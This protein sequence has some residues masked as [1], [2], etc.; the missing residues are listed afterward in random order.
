MAGRTRRTHAPAFKAK[1]AL[2]AIK[3]EKTLAGLAQHYD[4]HPNQITAWK[5]QLVEGAQDISVSAARPGDRAAEP[6]LGE[7]GQGSD[8]AAVGIARWRD[9]YHV[10]P[11]GTRL[12]LPRGRGELV[13]PAGFGLAAFDHNGVDFCIDA[14]EEALAKYGRPEIF[15]TDQGAQFTSAF[16][17]VCVPQ[18][19]RQ[20][21]AACTGLLLE[22]K[23]AISMHG[24]GSWRDD[25]FVERL[26]RSVKYEE[27][28]LRAYES[29]GDARASLGSIWLVFWCAASSIVVLREANR[30]QASIQHV[31]RRS[32]THTNRRM[33]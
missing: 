21:S 31:H 14:V 18:T 7:A 26:W 11:D 8:G 17:H 15:N 25:V 3:G 2:A 9:G 20:T 1:V 32:R 33:R 10:H 13:H 27:V 29:V 4:V 19:K 16:R 5:G 30:G 24:R 28:Y 22:N 6:S 23:I 12:R